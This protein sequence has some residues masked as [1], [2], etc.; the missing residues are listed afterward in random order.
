MAVPP[1]QQ[2][3]G[4]PSRWQ[5]PSGFDASCRSGAARVLEAESVSNANTSL[6]RDVSHPSLM[7]RASPNVLRASARRRSFRTATPATS[8]WGLLRPE[9]ALERR[10]RGRAFLAVVGLFLLLAV[11]V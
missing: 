2:E 6:V 5:R 9:S 7:L 4:Q 8:L 11:V 1:T 3:G 10:D